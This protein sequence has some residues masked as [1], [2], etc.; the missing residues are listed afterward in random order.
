MSDLAGLAAA[1]RSIERT[2]ARAS[3]GVDTV[4]APGPQRAYAASTSLRVATHAGR[5]AGKTTGA[6]VRALV[7]SVR[8]PLSPVLYLT[9]TRSNAKEIFWPE[10]LALNERYALGGEVRVSELSIRL[11]GGAP[12]V[13]RGADKESELAKVRGKHFRRVIIDE[14]SYFRHGFLESLI[15]RDLRA[16][17]SDYTGALVVMGTPPPLASGFFYDICRGRLSAKWDVHHW[18]LADNPR[19]PALASGRSARDVF[20]EVLDEFGWSESDPTFRREY[21]GEF[22]EDANALLYAYDDAVNGVDDI[23]ERGEWSTVM[24]ID[25]GSDDRTAVVVLGWRAHERVLYVLAE[26]ATPPDGRTDIDDVVDIVRPLAERWQP[27]AMV[28]DQGGLGKMIANTLRERYALPVE[29]ADKSRKGEHIALMNT[30]LR[31]GR[32]RCRR[33]SMFAADARRVERC[34]RALAAG[35]IEERAGGYHSDITDA[36]LYAWRRARHYAEVAAPG[37]RDE[38]AEMEMAAYRRAARADD[39]ASRLGYD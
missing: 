38:E 20:R 2:S 30:D 24:G 23:D 34:P 35:R 18:T 22:V 33:D 28:I 31:R 39:I 26:R 37:A 27:E 16:A 32:L 1:L 36:V 7:E 4:C 14:A 8:H 9:L 19:H 10:L 5:R 3:F 12:I 29:A 21:M 11:P 17:L 25:L 13:L 6:A 15:Q